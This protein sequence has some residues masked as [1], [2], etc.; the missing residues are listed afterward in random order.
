LKANGSV[1]AIGMNNEGQCNTGDWRDIVA[2]IVGFLCT[3]GLKADGT[4]VAV[5]ENSHGQCNTSDW[6]NI[7]PVDKEKMKER[8]EAERHRLEEEKRRRKEEDRKREEDK[9]KKA[10][11]EQRRIDQ[12][13]KWASQGL[14]RHCG[15]QMGGLFTKKCKSCGRE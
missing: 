1:V 5:G 9:R 13:N 3:V 7:G 12:S 4:V 6:C 11:E 8:I 10:E 15:G 2:V 14:C